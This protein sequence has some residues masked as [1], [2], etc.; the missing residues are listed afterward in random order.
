[1]FERLRPSPHD[2][3]LDVAAG[4]GHVARALAASVR[5]VIAVD[6]TEAMLAA[7]K[8]EAD[9]AGLRNVVF[10][11]GD[12]AALPFADG[13]FDIVLSRFAL[14]HFEQP[15]VQVREMARCLRA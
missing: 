7:G 2:L 3:V 13:S 4:T 11:R 5:A 15:A 12:A 6:A 10:Q 1:M 8:A 14:H 9:R